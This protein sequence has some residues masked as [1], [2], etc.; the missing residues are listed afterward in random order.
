MWQ[1]PPRYV[2]KYAEQ[3]ALITLKLWENLKVK[4]NKEECSSIFQLE[5]DLLPVL[6]EMKTKGVRVDIEK[7]HKTKEQLAKIEKSL[8][9]EIVKETG[10]TVEPWVATSVA[11]VFDAVGLPYSRTEKSGSPMFTKQFL[12]NQTHPIAQK[13]IK[14]REINKANTTFVDTILE[15]SH[16]GRIH[17]DFHSLRSDGGGTVT[18]RFSSSNP[19]LQQIPARS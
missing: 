5:T 15:H 6:F 11:K 7:A 9:E 4:L 8:I 10:V 12:A 3:D 1:L 14:I 18:G 13:I 17:C 19:N 16:N 2:G